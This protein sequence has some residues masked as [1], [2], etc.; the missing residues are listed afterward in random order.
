MIMKKTFKGL[1]IGLII[2]NL[3]TYTNISMASNKTDLQNE[4]SDLDNSIAEAKDNLN[5][6]E[7]EKSETLNQVENLMGQISDYQTEIDDLESEI[8]HLQTQIKDAEKKIKE[9]EEDYKKKQNALNERLVAMYE[10][11]EVSYLDVLLSS[12]S[13]TDFISNYYM[14]SELTTYDTEMLKQVEE[15]KQKIENE[16]KELETSKTSLDSAKEKKESKANA[17]KVAKKEKEQKASELSEEEKSTQKE[18]EEMLEDKAI[19][20]K[21]L[22]KIAQQEA[23]RLERERREAEERR[24]AEEKA[25]NNKNSNK[26]TSSSSSSSS[27]SS[28]GSITPSP[29][30]FIFPVAGCSKAN[31]NNKNYP[32]YSGHTGVDVNIGVVGKNVVA[33]KAGTVTTSTALKNSNGSYRS[34]GE[35]VV[36]NHGDGTLTLYAH[37]L[38]GSRKVQQNQKVTQGQVIGTV[39]STGN[40]SGTHLH[41]EVQVLTKVGGTYKFRPVN[42]L[43]YLP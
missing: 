32:S 6:I 34:Y 21:E 20:D 37:M 31:I 23:E 9:D 25:N 12:S 11:G 39:G 41:F 10:N 38:A 22:Q 43:P 13:L 14:V 18:I 27:S 40:S 3:M 7:K 36:I 8:S 19:I 30:G 33:V 16:K 26:N 29:S 4:K 35:Y 1:I 42:P 2:V 28:T 24:K 17:L 5:Q 15:E